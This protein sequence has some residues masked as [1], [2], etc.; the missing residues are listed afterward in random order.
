MPKTR[1]ESRLV[2]VTAPRRI[3]GFVVVGVLLAVLAFTVRGIMRDAGPE[4]A[5]PEEMETTPD[6]APITTVPRDSVLMTA[7][8]A[9]MPANVVSGQTLYVPVYSNIRQLAGRLFRLTA[10]LSVRNTDVSHPIT[11]T[12]VDFY[13]H[14]GEL[15]RSYVD[16]DSPQKL[17]PLAM[18]EYV[19]DWRDTPG[20]MGASFIVEWVAGEE[21]TQPV[22]E[23][24]MLGDGTRGLAFLSRGIIIGDHHEDD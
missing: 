24:V 23:S 21:V 10:N 20:G 8:L 4:D 9:E 18:A 7:S 6:V 19:L 12:V 5:G 11:V 2:S 15:L 14:N 16:S 13:D 3:F 1:E 22:V 17:G